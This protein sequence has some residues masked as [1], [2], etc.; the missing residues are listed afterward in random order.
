M[1]CVRINIA[2]NWPMPHNFDAWLA[3][4]VVERK[5]WRDLVI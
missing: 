2:E 1:V 5:I 3:M 4:D